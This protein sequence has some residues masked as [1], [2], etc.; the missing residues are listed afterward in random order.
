MHTPH[1]TRTRSTQRLRRRGPLHPNRRLR[2]PPGHRRRHPCIIRRPRPRRTR[3]RMRLRN[4]Q[5]RRRHRLALE[6]RSIK[7]QIRPGHLTRT[8]VAQLQ[9]RRRRLIRAITLLHERVENRIRRRL[10]IGR[11]HRHRERALRRVQPRHIRHHTQ[12]R[13]R[14]LPLPLHRA[15]PERCRLHR[16]VISV[17]ARTGIPHLRSGQPT[18]R[19]LRRSIHQ[20]HRAVLAGRRNRVPGTRNHGR[21][22]H[23]TRTTPAPNRLRHALAGL[24]HPH[25]LKTHRTH[26]HPHIHPRHH[27]P[28][29][30]RR[31]LHHRRAQRDPI[32][33]Q[34]GTI[35]RSIGHRHHL[36]TTHAH[37]TWHRRG[38]RPRRCGL[39]RRVNRPPPIRGRRR[40]VLEPH[41][42]RRN[43]LL[44]M[45]IRMHP[46]TP[47]FRP[48]GQHLHPPLRRPRRHRRRHPI[49]TRHLPIQRHQTIRTRLL[50]RHHLHRR[51]CRRRLISPRHIPRRHRR[52][53]RQRRRPH[54]P[55]PTHRHQPAQTP[56]RHDN[57]IYDAA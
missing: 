38:Y 49:R 51:R 25:Q 53:Q 36:V 22:H 11:I 56:T 46:Y 35:T 57:P 33:R 7:I 14:H 28:I 50:P 40:R 39:Q 23:L 12:R 34:R 31:T 44:H 42:S 19:L 24:D 26:V 15:Q 52:H 18:P 13:L 20:L 41:R 5:R 27:I 1:R 17:L 29:G 4:T 32:Q 43:L 3:P 45:T 21:E 55:A 48:L 6:R 30:R 2:R 37:C 10:R 54:Q 8:V 9:L 47:G 16:P